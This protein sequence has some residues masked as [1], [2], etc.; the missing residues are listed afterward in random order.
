MKPVLNY[1]LVILLLTIRGLSATAQ[2]PQ[3][4]ASAWEQHPEGVALAL[5]LTKRTEY[6]QQTT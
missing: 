2:E 1:L 6:N 5:M 4:P 3:I